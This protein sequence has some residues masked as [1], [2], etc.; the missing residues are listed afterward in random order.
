MYPVAVLAGGLGT[1]LRELSGDDLPKALLPL[2]GRPFIDWKLAGLAAAGVQQV[3]LLVGH[4]ADQIRA[5]VGDGA[6]FGVEVRCID[7]GPQ[8]LGTGGALRR[9]L[10]ELPDTFWVTYG[11]SLLEV[12]LRAAQSTLEGSPRHSLMTVLHNRDR[13]Q[14]SNVVVDRGVVVAYHK[15]PPP[16]AAQ[17]IDYGMLLLHRRAWDSFTDDLP[18]D[19]ADVLAPL[20]EARQLAAYEVSSRFHDIGTPDAVRETE[21]FLR[22]LSAT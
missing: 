2:L 18:F 15:D 10:P 17:H 16:P 21:S 7:D 3:V 9:A 1:R 20:V 22:T 19:L 14:P 11:D 6:R 4:R 13:W 8:L 12:D 5:H